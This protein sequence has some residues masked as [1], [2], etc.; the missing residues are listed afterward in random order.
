MDIHERI[1]LLLPH[2]PDAEIARWVE[3]GVAYA[4]RLERLPAREREAVAQLFALYGLVPDAYYKEIYR[5]NIDTLC[6]AFYPGVNN[7]P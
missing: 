4:D 7:A 3:G 1:R 2:A 6:R 5:R